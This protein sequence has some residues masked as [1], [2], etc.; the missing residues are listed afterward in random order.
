MR[1]TDWISILQLLA[2]VVIAVLGRNKLREI[3]V[4]VNSRL[5]EALT[6]IN[7]LKQKLG[8]QPRKPK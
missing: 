1:M 3:H 6:E 4:L 7:V 8:L 5:T 2:V